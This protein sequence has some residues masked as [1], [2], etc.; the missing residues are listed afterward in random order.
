LNTKARGRKDAK[1]VIV[2]HSLLVAAL[3][4]WVFRGLKCWIHKLLFIANSSARVLGPRH[5]RI[6]SR[7]ADANVSSSKKAIE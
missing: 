1:E 6:S 7:V 5:S 4:R 2:H 3:L